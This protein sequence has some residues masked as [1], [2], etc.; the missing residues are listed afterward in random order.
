MMRSRSRMNLNAV[1]LFAVRYAKGIDPSVPVIALDCRLL[2]RIVE[3]GAGQYAVSDC[4]CS[5]CE[6]GGIDDPCCMNAKDLTLDDP[7]SF[8]GRMYAFRGFG[9]VDIIRYETADATP[10]L[11][12][13]VGFS[14]KPEVDMHDEFLFS[15]GAMKAKV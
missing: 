15:S 9:D 6:C 11:M 7:E 3:S 13:R 14:R 5:E 12:R 1:V 10:N 8:E 2:E 4:D